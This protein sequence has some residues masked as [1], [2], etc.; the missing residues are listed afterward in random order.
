MRTFDSKRRD[1]VPNQIG[2]HV[3]FLGPALRPWRAAAVSEKGQRDH[4]M[5][6]LQQRKHGRPD[7]SGSAYAMQENERLAFASFVAFW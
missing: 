7:V 1:F 4:A 5:M 6:P 2:Q 3:D